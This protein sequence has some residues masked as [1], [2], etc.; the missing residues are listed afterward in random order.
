MTSIQQNSNNNYAFW[1][2]VI[3]HPQITFIN[4]QQTIFYCVCISG[5]CH[6]N[7]IGRTTMTM[8]WYNYRWNE[9]IHSQKIMNLIFLFAVRV[10]LHRP[11]MSMDTRKIHSRNRKKLLIHENGMNCHA[12]KRKALKRPKISLHV[13]IVSHV[14]KC[15]P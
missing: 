2:A 9:D 13:W 11:F 12:G 15:F 1:I 10:D 8:S 14:Q 5:Y 6:L 3:K 7:W 4:R